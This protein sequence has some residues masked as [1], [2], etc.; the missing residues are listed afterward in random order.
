MEEKQIVG[1]EKGWERVPEDVRH[2]DFGCP[3]CLWYGVECKAGGMYA[4]EVV[5]MRSSHC[6]NYAYCD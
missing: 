2:S 5:G 3:N 4:P 1:Q 6:Y